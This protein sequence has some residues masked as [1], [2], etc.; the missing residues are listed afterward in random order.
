MLNHLRFTESRCA[1]NQSRGRRAEHHPTRRSDRLHPLRHPDLLTNGGVTERPRTDLTGDHLTGVQSHPQPQVHTVAVLDL[2]GK[3]L[4]LLLNAQGRQTGTNGVVLQ[5]HR[6]AE[7][8]HDP[9][10]GELVHRA[11]VPLHHRRAAV[12]QLG[13]DLAQPLRTDRRRDVHRMH[14]VGEQ[15]RHLLVLRR[16]ADLCDRCTALVTELGVRWQFG[17]A[18]PTEQPRRC[19]STATIPAGVHV[20]IVSPLL[21][22]VRHI[23]V[24]SPTRSFETLVCRLIRDGRTQR[25]AGGG[26]K[27]SDVAACS[28]GCLIRVYFETA[29]SSVRAWSIW[30]YA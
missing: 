24:P 3:P 1:L 5:R 26:S 22:D 14:H 15:H 30:S 6:R 8:R 19:Q 7:H 13:H 11:A 25:G 27:V 16:S 17:A 28:A 2:D 18:R 12:D 9:V 29:F 21:S 20:S 23:A 4:R 10:A